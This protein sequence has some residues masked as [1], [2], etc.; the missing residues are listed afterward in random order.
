[1]LKHYIPSGRV[2]RRLKTSPLYKHILDLVGYFH[3][4]GYRKHVVQRYVQ[5]IEH[6]CRWKADE[7]R[8]VV[9]DKKTARRFI[10]E[11]LPVC[12]CPPPAPRSMRT[13]RAALNHLVRTVDSGEVK[14]V[15][16]PTT[17]SDR[18]IE[19][20]IGHLQRNRGLAEETLHYRARY[21]REFLESQFSSSENNIRFDKLK[22]QNVMRFVTNY[23]GRCKRSSTQLAAGALRDFLR[24]LHMR[25]LCR[26]GLVR[27][28]PTIRRWKQ[29][30]LPAVMT[31]EQLS[32]FLG[33]FD[34][35]TPIGCRDYAMVLYMAELGLR[36]SEVA[37]ISLDD[38]EWR[39]GVLK[40]HLPKPRNN[41]L[42]PLTRRVGQ[43]TVRYLKCGRPSSE[44]RQLFLRHLPP[45]GR[46]VSRELIRGAIRR[47][48]K[49]SGCPE[50]WTGTHIL[51]R[52]AATRLHC[53]GASL[54]E[55]ADLLGHQS[56]D[57]SAIYTRV[58]IAQLAS[59]AM[60]WPGERA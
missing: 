23:A 18:L 35:F 30:G 27:A 28:V 59:V 57:T 51:R 47:A 22:P 21:A 37:Q 44:S 38:I 9:V 31:K 32:R 41:R 29:E 10:K 19:E 4:E 17:N 7:G 45:L 2:R 24:F 40:I 16:R 26:E 58:N 20:Y 52:T 15:S 8:R 46:P 39:N 48:Y 14:T 43:A 1:M 56:I 13:V 3:K 11:H 50:S 5:V 6:F 49:R 60:P 54:K 36:V 33:A 42:L 25:G 34:R 12:D 55:I 53:Q